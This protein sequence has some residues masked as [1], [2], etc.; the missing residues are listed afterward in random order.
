MRVRVDKAGEEQLAAD[1][2]D[3][4]AVRGQMLADLDDLLSVDQKICDA[5]TGGGDDGAAFE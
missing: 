2:H 3:G 5:G 1:V 4:C